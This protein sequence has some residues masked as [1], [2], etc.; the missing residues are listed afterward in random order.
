M[1]KTLIIEGMSCGH[2]AAH[3]KKALEEI[4][5]VKSAVVDVET[6]K[7]EVEL[8]HEVEDAKFESA[9]DEIGYKV[10]SIN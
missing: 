6:K 10:V 4:C 7:A 3:T 1:K 9:I 8:A 5:G 2:C